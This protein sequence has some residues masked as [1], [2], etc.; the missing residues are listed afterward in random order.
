LEVNNSICH[1]CCQSKGSSPKNMLLRSKVKTRTDHH[2]VPSATNLRA[3]QLGLASCLS[4]SPGIR[5]ALACTFSSQLVT[6]ITT[7]FPLIRASK[8]LSHL[9]FFYS[10]ISLS[11]LYNSQ[12][13]STLQLKS[14][15]L[16]LCIDFLPSSCLSC[17]STFH[18]IMHCIKLTSSNTAVK[19]GY[20]RGMHSLECYSI[21]L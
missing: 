20:Q 19:L 18:G 7:V 14:T 9:F 17:V 15:L 4:C 8:I 2:Q 1:F 11:F 5:A 16:Y 12:V 10:C 3:S 6:W 21:F 13:A